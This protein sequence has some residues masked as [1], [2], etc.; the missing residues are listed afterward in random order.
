MKALTV[1]QPWASLIAIGAKPYEFRGWPAPRFVRGVRIAIHAGAR[2]LRRA[3]VEE[4]LLRLDSQDA[5]ATGLRP[6]IA[7]PYLE[8]IHTSPGLVPLSSVLC[9]AILGEPVNAYDVMPQF[10]GFPGIDSDRSQANYAW[11]LTEIEAF[12][13]PVDA[14]GAQGFWNWSPQPLLHAV[15][16]A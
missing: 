9:T 6:E 5:W 7:V 10:A 4:L 1:W 13:P 3:E 8:R 14:K 2:P 11:P 16:P 15:V 12:W